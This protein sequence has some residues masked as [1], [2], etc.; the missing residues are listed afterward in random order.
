MSGLFSKPKIP[1][2]VPTVQRDDAAAATQ[3][4]DELRR[5]RG[6]AADMLTGAGGAEATGITAKALTGQ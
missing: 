4:D 2:L 5:R 1:G 6:S 3:R